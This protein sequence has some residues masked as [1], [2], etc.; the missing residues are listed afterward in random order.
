MAFGPENPHAM[1]AFRINSHDY[2]RILGFTSPP[3]LPP[4]APHNCVER[5]GGERRK[6]LYI[7]ILIF[8][9]WCKDDS[10]TRDM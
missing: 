10:K 9:L 7:Y 1:L 8:F 4:P 2:V 5:G 6:F 3:L